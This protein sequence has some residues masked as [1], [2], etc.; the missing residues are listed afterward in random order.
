M[1]MKLVGGS[2]RTA[3]G[4]VLDGN[5]PGN[6]QRTIIFIT[7][8]QT[9]DWHGLDPTNATT[10]SRVQHPGK[11]MNAYTLRHEHLNQVRFYSYKWMPVK[12]CIFLNIKKRKM[13][14]P[15]TLNRGEISYG[16]TPINTLTF[17]SSSLVPEGSPTSF[18]SFNFVW[19]RGGSHWRGR[20]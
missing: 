8:A 7:K 15:S 18:F 5:R 16:C 4:F 19:C 14:V 2:A 12:L 10:P 11:G 17:L 3:G 13:R 1:T 9:E 20:I 6:D